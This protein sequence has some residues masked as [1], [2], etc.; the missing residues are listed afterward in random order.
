MGVIDFP[1]LVVDFRPRIAQQ[2]VENSP[3]IVA[4]ELAQR[5]GRLP[6]IA[7]DHSQHR[8][9]IGSFKGLDEVLRSS[10]RKSSPRLDNTADE[11]VIAKVQHR[12]A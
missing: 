2:L 6:K 8:R 9:Q 10:P 11:V 3:L 1:Q 4:K 5:I 7:I 12:K